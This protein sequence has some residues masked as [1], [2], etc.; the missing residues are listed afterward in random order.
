MWRDLLTGE[1]QRDPYVWG[2]VALSH[3]WIGF[4]LATLAGCVLPG[5]WA[6]ALVLPAYAAWEWR[7][8]LLADGVLDWCAVAL[9]ACAVLWPAPAL[10]AVWAVVAAGVWVRSE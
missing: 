1:A 6:A 2:S 10:L 4:S 8:G 3:A 9:G 5:A 7:Q